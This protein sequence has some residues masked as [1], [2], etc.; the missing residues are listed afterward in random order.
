MSKAILKKIIGKC[1]DEP[2][3]IE[4]FD[5]ELVDLINAYW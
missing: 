4:L 2:L 5:Q 3:D 1:Y